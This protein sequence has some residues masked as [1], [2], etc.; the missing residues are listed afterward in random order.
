MKT[1]MFLAIAFALFAFSS[2]NMDE[3]GDRVQIT[4]FSVD[5]VFIE[6]DTAANHTLYVVG[7]QD[8]FK[9]S[10]STKYKIDALSPFYN[11]SMNTEEW[12]DYSEYDFSIDYHDS[13]SFIV[14]ALNNQRL[15]LYLE[16]DRQTLL[17]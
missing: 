8:K 4:H 3:T 15:T 14:P 12:S 16:Y 11:S 17:P 2:C 13:C 1:D 10:A 7:N 9:I 6:Q 5:S